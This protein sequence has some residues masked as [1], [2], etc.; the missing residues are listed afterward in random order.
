MT[1]LAGFDQPD[2]TPFQL[3]VEK[4]IAWLDESQMLDESHLIVVALI[5]ELADV[6][7]KSAGRGRGSSVALASKE[8]REA[9]LLLPQP[10]GKADPWETLQ[11][12]MQAAAEAAKARATGAPR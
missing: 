10:G 4:Q 5:R 7:G 12:E 11:S 6:I 8:L 1:M 9:L 2:Q 3:A